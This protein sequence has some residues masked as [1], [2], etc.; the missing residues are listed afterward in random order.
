MKPPGVATKE[1]SATWEQYYDHY[2]D[3]KLIP[4]PSGRSEPR[5]NRLDRINGWTVRGGT[6]RLIENL[7]QVR[8]NA[9]SKGRL[10]LTA[11]G[12]EL[13]RNLT[14]VV[15]C[16]SGQGGR[17]G[18]AWREKGEQEFSNDQVVAFHCAASPNVQEHRVAI[19]AS[20]PVIH[21][22]LLTPPGGADI[23]SIEFLG[24]DEKQVRIWKFD[25]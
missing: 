16:R 25:R 22:R 24:E 12:L 13:P 19:A 9:S 17:A 11:S 21:V 10:F 8:P 5:T 20:K 15:R 2:L 3:G 18:I 7:L 14:A 1:M 4:P 23:E 6:V